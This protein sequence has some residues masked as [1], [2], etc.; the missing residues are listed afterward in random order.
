MREEVIAI[1]RRAETHSFMSCFVVW[2]IFRSRINYAVH[3]TV[4]AA[5]ILPLRLSFANFSY[6]TGIHLASL[7]IPDKDTRICISNL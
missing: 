5:V 4:R 1:I 7:S 2:C 6:L 3:G